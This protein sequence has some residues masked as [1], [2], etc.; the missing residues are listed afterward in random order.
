MAGNES[1]VKDNV[2]AT[3][4]LLSSPAGV[5]I[6]SLGA[7]VFADIKKHR[8]RKILKNGSITTIAGT[9]VAGYGGLATHTKLGSW[10]QIV[11]DSAGN[12]YI[13]DPNSYAVRMVDTSGNV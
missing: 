6:D 10:Q 1:L 13:A 2:S 12:L 11:F 3:Q 5:A 8:I 4:N 9:G 7:V